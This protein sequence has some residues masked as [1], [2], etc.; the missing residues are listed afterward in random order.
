MAQPTLQYSFCWGEKS[1]NWDFQAENWG[2]HWRYCDF[3]GG[4]YYF[5]S[6]CF[7]HITWAK[8]YD[9][10]LKANENINIGFFHQ[11]IVEELL[12]LLGKRRKENTRDA[13]LFGILSMWYEFLLSPVTDVYICDICIWKA[14][15]VSVLLVIPLYLLPM[16]VVLTN[17]TKLI[18]Q[19]KNKTF[20]IMGSC[21]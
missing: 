6:C 7:W 16:I 11:I 19:L 12:K 20:V 17:S 3:Q 13:R 4:C 5:P 14:Y 21:K 10:A 9:M 15:K 18:F 2:F 8:W 1:P